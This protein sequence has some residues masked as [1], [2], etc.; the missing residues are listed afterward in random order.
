M[1]IYKFEYIF[2]RVFVDA[3]F[4]YLD[5]YLQTVVYVNVGNIYIYW[6]YRITVTS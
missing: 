3:Y 1:Y 4:R 6:E 2:G 5:M